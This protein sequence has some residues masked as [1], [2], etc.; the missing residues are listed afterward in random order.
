MRWKRQVLAAV[1][2]GLLG[3]AAHAQKVKH[4]AHW[5]FDLRRLGFRNP[6]HFPFGFNDPGSTPFLTF[7]RNWVAV[8]FDA[9]SKPT[10]ANPVPDFLIVL[11]VFD[12]VSGRLWRRV[13]IFPYCG[14]LPSISVA[15]TAE[16]NLLYLENC[17][18][19]NARSRVVGW[20]TRLLLLTPNLRVIRK[21]DMPSSGADNFWYMNVSATGRSLLLTRD[22]GAPIQHDQLLDPD[23]LALRKEWSDNVSIEGITDTYALGAPP[24]SPAHPG[25]PPALICPFNGH[26]T[27][28]PGLRGYFAPLGSSELL[29]LGRTPLSFAVATVGGQR[30]SGSR[31]SVRR[32]KL[33]VQFWKAAVSADGKRFALPL[34]VEPQHWY[35]TQRQFVFVYDPPSTSPVFRLEVHKVVW[36][37]FSPALSPDG[38]LLAVISGARLKVYALPAR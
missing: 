38:K 17:P 8:S 24:F 26:W 15:A 1:V 23:T 14:G 33:S 4:K 29:G 10:R 3:S 30:V 32:G 37:V 20:A 6:G 5:Q 11:A 18:I 21:I 9:L 2:V 7:S 25:P 22:A 35:Q 36:S 28:V 34:L 13:A 27:P 16:G 19:Q 12:A 31:L